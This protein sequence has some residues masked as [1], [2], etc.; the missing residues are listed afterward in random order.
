MDV[1]HL[2][3]DE[4]VSSNEFRSVIGYKPSSDPRADKL[5][6]KNIAQ[7]NEDPNNGVTIKKGDTNDVENEE[8]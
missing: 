6:N 8:V 3:C 1:K 7:S 5:I 4:I 2:A